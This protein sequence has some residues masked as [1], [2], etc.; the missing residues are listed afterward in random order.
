MFSEGFSQNQP[1]KWLYFDFTGY[2]SIGKTFGLDGYFKLKCSTRFVV[3]GSYCRDSPLRKNRWIRKTIGKITKILPNSK[4]SLNF[5][6]IHWN[7]HLF[8][9]AQKDF[10]IKIKMWKRTRFHISLDST[11]M[12]TLMS[13]VHAEM[14]ATM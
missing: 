6:K 7:F 14:Q 11:H 8:C 9:S 4:F 3:A 10:N 5:I 1:L 13:K 2:I 12:S